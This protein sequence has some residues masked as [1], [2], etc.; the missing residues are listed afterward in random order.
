MQTDFE[1]VSHASI[2]ETFA[3]QC[4]EQECIYL[5]KKLYDGIGRM[6]QELNEALEK[7]LGKGQFE[8]WAFEIL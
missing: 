7:D 8:N 5:L 6:S 4:V 1:S 2:W 3:E